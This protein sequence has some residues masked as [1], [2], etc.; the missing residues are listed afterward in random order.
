VSWARRHRLDSIGVLAAFVYGLP[1]LA[2]RYGPD[3]AMFHYVAREWLDGRLPYR[4]VFDVKPP[5]IFVLEAILLAVFGESEVVLRAAALVAVVAVGVLAALAFGDAGPATGPTTR[6]SAT[7]PTATGPSAT[8]P[9]TTGPSATGPTTTGPS[10]TGP[11][12]TGPSAEPSTTWPAT[13]GPT[14]TGLSGPTTGRRDGELGLGALLAVGWHYGAF[15]FYHSAQTELF[16][17]LFLMGG[18]V[19]LRR[20]RDVLGGALLSVAT[21]FKLTAVLPAALVLAI[22]VRRDP[23]WVSRTARVTLGGAIP[24]VLFVGGYALV[25]LFGSGGALASLRDY[26][27]LVAHYGTSAKPSLLARLST[28]W[29][30]N[31]AWLLVAFA[32]AALAIRERT[33]DPVGGVSRRRVHDVGRVSRRPVHDVGGVSRRRVHDVGGV[34]RRRVLEPL[35]LFLASAGAVLT[36]GKLSAYQWDVTSGFLV[37][38]LLAGLRVVPLRAAYLAAVVLLAIPLVRPDARFGQHVR[39]LA[40]G[41]SVTA[42]MEHADFL[43]AYDEQTRMAEAIAARGPRPGDLLHVRGYEPTVYVLTGLSSPARFFENHLHSWWVRDFDA[44]DDAK[45]DHY[46]RLGAA[47]PRFFATRPELPIDVEVLETAGYERFAE[48]GRFTLWERTRSTAPKPRWPEGWWRE[49]ERRA[50]ERQAPSP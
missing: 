21:L 15:D 29:L 34:S 44:L 8:G 5:G 2:Y 27:E 26:L 43:Y 9:T 42:Q 25:D 6:A 3:Q 49:A 22:V 14:T 4:D 46:A 19:A 45:R 36:Q 38:L 24:Y 20:R 41:E 13:A 28:F 33:R 18:L 40:T 11:T 31:A 50:R 10:A 30:E 23:R 47:A 37:A 39:A 48:I 17:A 32:G 7:G 16:Q 35:G 1:S 12:T